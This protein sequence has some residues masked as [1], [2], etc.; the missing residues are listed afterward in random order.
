MK[1][2]ISYKVL[3]F[4]IF[5]AYLCRTGQAF[6]DTPKAPFNS[7]EKITYEI[8]WLSIPAGEATIQLLPMEYLNGINTYH[9]LFTV[10]SN[11]FI[12]TFYKVR[13]KVEAYTDFDISHSLLYVVK[14]QEGNHQNN[15]VINFDWNKKQA[16]Y[17]PIDGLSKNEPI[18]IATGTFD[19]LSVLLS[20]RL[21]DLSKTNRVE[22]PVTDGKKMVIGKANVIRKEIIEINGTNYDTYLIEPEI[23]KVGGVFEPGKD[24][25]LQVWITA[26]YRRIP[27]RIKS[28]VIIGSFIAELSSYSEGV[29]TGS[30]K[31]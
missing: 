22:I 21:K 12:D 3:A 10:T 5:L 4:F 20:F 29:G 25:T 7:G 6:G 2:F 9:I 26:D 19:P 31:Q 24:A 13:N 16:Q 18:S 30:N 17:T 23:G 27:V 1:Y 11:K 15:A 28:K 8:R 14:N